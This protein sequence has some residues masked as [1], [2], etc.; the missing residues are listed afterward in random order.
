MIAIFL[1]IICK[2]EIFAFNLQYQKS[3]MYDDDGQD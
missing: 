2:C 3:E 1:P